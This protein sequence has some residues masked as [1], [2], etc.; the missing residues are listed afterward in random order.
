MFKPE[1]DIAVTV[2]ENFSKIVLN[3]AR[4]NAIY[5][6]I[7]LQVTR[8]RFGGTVGKPLARSPLEAA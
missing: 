7:S 5:M 2:G 6:S 4:T 8:Q 1:Q 3:R